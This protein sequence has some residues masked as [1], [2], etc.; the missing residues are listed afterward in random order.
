[1]KGMIS[2]LLIAG[3]IM[4]NAC[5]PEEAIKSSQK[6]FVTFTVNHQAGDATIDAENAK[7]S[8]L[9][10]RSADLTA[11]TPDFTLSEG[12][13]SSPVSGQV[14]D[15]SGGAVNYL[16]TAEDKSTKNWEV[17]VNNQKSSEAK[18][19][20]FSVENQLTDFVISDDAVTGAVTPKTDWTKIAPVIVISDAA[21]IQPA[22]GAETD[23]SKGAVSY[24]VTAED[25][26]LKT[27]S[28]TINKD[29]NNEAK[30]VSVKVEGQVGET[31]KNSSTYTVHMPWGSSLAALAPVFELAVGA[32]I[33][34]ASG[35]VHDFSSGA[36][37]YTVTSED[38]SRQTEWDVKA[39]YAVIPANDPKVQYMGR[40]SFNDK[41]AAKIWAPGVMVRF[42]FK[43]NYCEL[44][45]NDENL[46]GSNYNYLEISVDGGEPKRMRTKDKVNN[47][48]F[49]GLTDGEHLVEITKDTESG[50]G[51]IEIV[52]FH[53]PEL[54]EPDA[55][56]TR[57][58]EFIGNSITCGAESFTDNVACDQGTWF[59]RH[60]ASAAYGPKTAKAL[61][62]QW[63][64]TSLSG[65]GLIHSCCDMTVVMPQI[66]DKVKLYSNEIAWDFSRYM[67]NVVT[68]CLGQNDGVQDSATFCNCYVS[69]IHTIRGKYPNAQIVL[70]TS[71][72]DDGPLTIFL[73]KMITS[74]VNTLNTEGDLNVSKFYF[75]K[76]WNGGCGY[77]P[78]VDEHTEIAN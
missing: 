49:S 57:K 58:I 28:V 46:Y 41:G 64:L 43:G 47:L 66:F 50:M 27:Y 56:P 68:V 60:K 67:P 76:A 53:T 74:V 32:T 23:F 45:L 75:S 12:A 63:Q 36:V 8:A 70:L 61:N 1:M 24:T 73:K 38:G 17:T 33:D 44:V 11:L 13:T 29:K 78:N 72:M 14:I 69:F 3:F 48:V 25:G 62:A 16:V 51:Y 59:D 30:I 35:S 37:T 34:P 5:K 19:I 20:S 21:T 55:L 52:G 10:E 54:V 7:V 2:S 15:F 4:V 9:V 42:K 65:V 6:E 71:P 26:T 77:H 31:N 40:V 22:S 39:D 18:I